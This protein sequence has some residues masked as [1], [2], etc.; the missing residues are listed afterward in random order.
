MHHQVH[1]WRCQ[2]IDCFSPAFISSL[3][4]LALLAL[5]SPCPPPP[6]RGRT[7][8]LLCDLSAAV[9]QGCA[10]AATGLS[11]C[12]PVCVKSS[13]KG[14]SSFHR[15]AVKSEKKEKKKSPSASV[16][17]HTC[18]SRRAEVAIGFAASC[19]YENG[20]VA[21]VTQRS[22]KALSR[23]RTEHFLL[24]SVYWLK[25]IIFRSSAA[26]SAWEIKA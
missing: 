17:L 7:P 13:I 18:T 9:L 22:F 24:L 19:F 23:W 15:E 25:S 26:A 12:P 2:R 21:L 14:F 5:L 3:D 10:A 4:T 11:V 16:S 6:A 1:I 8:T 20:I